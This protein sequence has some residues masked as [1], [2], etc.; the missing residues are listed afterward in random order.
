[1]GCT[2]LQDFY[3]LKRVYNKKIIQNAELIIIESNINE[4]TYNLSEI[5]RLPLEIIYRNLSYFYK[6]LYFLKTKILVC[7]LPCPI[8]NYKIINN[9]HRKFCLKYGFNLIDMHKYYDKFNL[10]SFSESVYPFYQ[11]QLDSIMKELGKNI[12]RF[13]N[14]FNFPKS[15]NIINDNPR[16]KICTPKDMELVNGVLKETQR[17]NHKYCEKRV[18]RL[19]KHTKLKFPKKFQGYFLLG[20]HTWNEIESDEFC[21]YSSLIVENKKTSISKES[22]CYNVVLEFHNK[23]QIDDKSFVRYNQNDEASYKEYYH[24][25]GSWRLN[26]RKVKHCDLIAFFLAKSNKIIDKQDLKFFKNLKTF[27]KDIKIPKK[28]DFSHLIPPVQVYEEVIKEY[29]EKLNPQRLEI[30][31]NKMKEFKFTS[32]IN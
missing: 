17:Q 20:V 19:E 10:F 9:M 22:S 15:L 11:H 27:S 7:L 25:R 14:D 30:L 2:L 21:E 13:L 23:F 1:M 29:C 16:F 8:G 12:C 28:Y 32:S 5:E 26:T 24:S 6:E 31:K 4:I 18:F 3:E